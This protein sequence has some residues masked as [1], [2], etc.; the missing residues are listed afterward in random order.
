MFILRLGINRAFRSLVVVAS[1]NLSNLEGGWSESGPHF[2]NEIK[3]ASWN[4]LIVRMYIR[5]KNI[6]GQMN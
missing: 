3:T 1:T 5:S 6:D 2:A 4:V